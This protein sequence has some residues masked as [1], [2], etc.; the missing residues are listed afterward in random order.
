VQPQIEDEER[1]LRSRAVLDY[2]SEFLPSAEAGP[3]AMI[4]KALID[5][6]GW[7]TPA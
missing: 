3:R 7:F 2:E 1:S 6:T 4:D 5:D